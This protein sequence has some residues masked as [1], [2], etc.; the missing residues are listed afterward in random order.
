M[1]IIL[2]YFWF[3]K[4]SLIYLPFL[5]ILA[6][7]AGRLL[8]SWSHKQKYLLVMAWILAGLLILGMLFLP[9]YRWI[10]KV[11]IPFLKP[12]G[13]M[14]AGMLYLIP[15]LALIL[16]TV[17]LSNGL[18][19]VRQQSGSGGES[20]AGIEFSNQRI[21][22][23]AMTSVILSGIL[24][25]VT[26]YKLFY[27]AVW[28][29]TTDSVNGVLL[30]GPFSAALISG[31]FISGRLSGRRKLYGFLYAVCLA[32]MILSVYN[33]AKKTNYYELTEAHADRIARSLYAYHSLTAQY[34]KNLRQLV[35]WTML[36]LPK[37]VIM[38][39]QDWCYQSGEN[40]YR[41]GYVSRGP[42]SSPY[43]SV[44]YVASAG[45]LPHH[46]DLCKAETEAILAREPIFSVVE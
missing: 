36:W 39:G 43:L 37:P 20:G 38:H 28:D 34:P 26:F 29:S 25:L 18:S 22:R 14:Y 40:Y 15:I 45:A 6:F 5:L 23:I 30:F 21:G 12:F 44:R 19:L 16:A 24:F 1:R 4:S 41:L 9:S 27:Q 3:F 17:L 42:W 35:P 32:A 8:R 11:E 46:P 10:D 13:A 31:A 7:L 2:D 33:H